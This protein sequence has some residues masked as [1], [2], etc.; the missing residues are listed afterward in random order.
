[1]SEI[2]EIKLPS[3]ATLKIHPAPFSVAKALCQAILKESKGISVHSK[4]DL[5]SIYKEMFCIGFS[6][7]SIEKCLWDCFKRCTY[8]HGAG[9]LK[10][11]DQTF[12]PLNARED[13]MTVCMEVAKENITPF[14]KS[15]MQEFSRILSTIES[16]HA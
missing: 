7:E 2:K 3:G 4:T 6:S 1:M 10:I 5:M 13:Y 11:D 12:E 9:D 16:T 15:L 14:T 8:N